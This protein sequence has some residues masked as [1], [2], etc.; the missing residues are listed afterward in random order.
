MAPPPRAE[1]LPHS[2]CRATTCQAGAPILSSCEFFLGN[3]AHRLIAYM[4]GVNHPNNRVFYNTKRVSD[5]LAEL[6][7]GDTSR[8][9]EGERNLRPDITDVTDLTAKR[10]FEIKPWGERGLQEGRQEVQLYLAA[11]NRAVAP[12]VLFTGGQSSRGRS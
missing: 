1:S 2:R 8:L 5:I 7:L 11:F 3:A 4:Y 9:L 12:A 10:V 6:E